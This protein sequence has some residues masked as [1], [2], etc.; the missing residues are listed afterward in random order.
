[1]KN[2]ITKSTLLLSFL[3]IANLASAQNGG[4]GESNILLLALMMAVAVIVFFLIIQVADNLMRIEAKNHGA[5][6]NDSNYSIFPAMNEIFRPKIK[7]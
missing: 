4:D 1:M 2:G 3:S 5:D 7:M 6:A